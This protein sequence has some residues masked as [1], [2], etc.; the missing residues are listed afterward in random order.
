MKRRSLLSLAIVLTVCLAA[1]NGVAGEG[2][3]GET[4]STLGHVRGRGPQAQRSGR[5]ERSEVSPVSPSPAKD[6]ASDWFMG[7]GRLYPETVPA[8]PKAPRGYVPVYLSHYGR[9]GSRYM[10]SADSYESLAGLLAKAAADSAL[11]ELGEDIWRRYSAIIPLLEKHEGELAPLGAQQHRQIATR[12]TRN[13]PRLFKAGARVEANSTNFERTILSMLNFEQALL[14]HQPALQ[15]SSDASR[16]EMGHIHQ[17]VIENPRATPEDVIWKGKQAPWRPAFDRY[18]E[19]VL[20][21]K[22]FCSSLFKDPDYILGLSDPVL[23]E[24]CYFEVAQ[25]LP[26]CPVDDCG[27]LRAF[28]PEELQNLGKLQNYSF[29]VEKGRWP[30]GNRRGCFLSE[31]VLG[32]IVERVPEDMASGVRVRLRFGHDGCMMALFALMKLE[33]W[34]SEIEDPADAWKVWDTSRV[35]MAANFQMVL[36]APRRTAPSPKP[37]DMLVLLMLNEE[38]LALPLTPVSGPFYR[39]SDFIS[40]CSALLEEARTALDA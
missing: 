2:L 10:P 13:Y 18:C 1:C 4:V 8:A 15:I 16:S 3:T 12:M 6:V 32:D 38:P 37:E 28:T 20:D 39:W 17:H 35:P 26:S 34:D 30:G 5:D 33:G 29:Y 22:P 27:L 25:N 9:H 14:Q 36:F 24:R 40:Y 23:F 11:T 19:S 31:S 21:W 7:T